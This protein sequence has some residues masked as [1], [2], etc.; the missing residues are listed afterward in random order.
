MRLFSADNSNVPFYPK[1]GE[2]FHTSTTTSSTVSC[3]TRTSLPCG[4]WI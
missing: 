1:V 4:C 2:L 3:S